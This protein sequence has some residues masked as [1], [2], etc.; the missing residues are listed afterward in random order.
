MNQEKILNIVQFHVT[1]SVTDDE[2][3]QI[4]TSWEPIVVFSVDDNGKSSVKVYSPEEGRTIANE[5]HMQI[6][7]ATSDYVVTPEIIE[8]NYQSFATIAG[9]DPRVKPKSNPTVLAKAKDSVLATRP[10]NASKATDAK[11]SKPDQ[12]VPVGKATASNHSSTQDL[13]DDTKKDSIFKR[14]LR[15]VA[16]PFIAAYGLIGK[17]CDWATEKF[18]R[19]KKKVKKATFGDRFKAW[20]AAKKGDATDKAKKFASETVAM[21]AQKKGAK[22]S[23]RNRRRTTPRRPA[24]KKGLFGRIATRVAAIVTPIALALGLTAASPITNASAEDTSSGVT[25]EADVD[26]TNLTDEELVEMIQSGELSLDQVKVMLA[27]GEITNDAL[28]GLSFDQ[29]LQVSNSD[30]QYQEMSK[31]GNYLD[32]FN[33]TFA[34]YYVESNHPDIRAALSWDEV[35]AINLAYNDFTTEEIRA[36]FNGYEVDSAEFTNSYKEA[37]LQLMGAFV[38]ETRD[39]PVDLSQLL[40]TQEG[41]EFYQKYNELFL[42]CKETT[43]QDQIDAVNAFY[44]ELHNDFPINADQREVGISHAE[45]RDDIDAY[46]LSVTPMVAA[47]EMMFQNLDIDHTLSDQAIAYFNDLGLCNFAQ[48]SFDKAETIMLCVDENESLPKYQQFADSKIQELKKEDRYFSSDRERDLSQLDLFQEWVNGH[49]D[50]NEAG[51]FVISQSITSTVVKTY[52]TSSTTYRT[53]H[54]ERSVSREEAVAAFGEDEVR[55]QEAEVNS[56]FDSWNAQQKA[57]GEAAAE[58]KRQDLQAEADKDAEAIRDEIAKDDQ[59]MQEDIEHANDTLEQGGTVNE[60]DFGDHDVDFDQDHSDSQGNLD[61]SVGSITE[62]GTGA[63][64]DL[65]DPNETGKELDD[66]EPDY[67][68]RPEG[69]ISGSPAESDFTTT[70]TSSQTMTNEEVADAIVEAMAAEDTATDENVYVYTK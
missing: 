15:S 46:K 59:D 68:N 48:G 56:Q 23:S 44:Q 34:N 62:D 28:D 17:A 35:S 22:N 3:N 12:T 10:V 31:I 27:T 66:N 47:A 24:S 61:G 8:K 52:S 43:G 63:D 18:L 5:N 58:Q 42:R 11:K 25:Q 45:T 54:S 30:I 39:M 41:Q 2:G 60:G 69:T 38:L 19:P 26:V 64:Q 67:S 37:T 21:K 50:L 65:P 51:E 7:G 70:D 6:L 20:F 9:F 13:D 40:N 57:E 32:Y 4:S 1:D 55:R 49:F 33:G 29:L 53:E 36:I 14:A 16:Y